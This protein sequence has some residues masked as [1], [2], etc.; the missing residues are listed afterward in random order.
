MFEVDHWF[1]ARLHNRDIVSS[2]ISSL[3]GACPHHRCSR[4]AQVVLE[5]SSDHSL[6]TGQEL[7]LDST[8]LQCIEMGQDYF[9][10]TFSFRNWA[11]AGEVRASVI[12]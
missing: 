12:S 5:R 7:A 8:T 2:L 1:E 10:S 11:P 6:M 3:R 9:G 4:C